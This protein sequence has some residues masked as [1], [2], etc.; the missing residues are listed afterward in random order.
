VQ[1]PGFHVLSTS[2][3]VAPTEDPTRV[4][5]DFPL[6]AIVRPDASPQSD[7][8]ANQDY[9]PR[10]AS[11]APSDADRRMYIKLTEQQT[12][13]LLQHMERHGSESFTDALRQLIE[14][15]PQK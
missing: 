4:M 2:V 15:L 6:V 8:P 3:L 11:L 7:A 13:T 14:S 5:R 9:S 10:H 12:R 1:A